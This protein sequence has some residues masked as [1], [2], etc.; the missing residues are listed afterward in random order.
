MGPKGSQVPTV[1]RSNTIT[2]VGYE[3]LSA[4]LRRVFYGYCNPQ[5]ALHVKRARDTC[6]G[7]KEASW[8]LNESSSERRNGQEESQ[9]NKISKINKGDIGSDGEQNNKEK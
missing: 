2:H 4:V 7:I 5:R 9:Q 1:N 6:D 3:H 8:E